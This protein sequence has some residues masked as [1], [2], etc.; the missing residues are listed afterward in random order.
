M[1]ALAASVSAILILIGISAIGFF[2]SAK[3]IIPTESLQFLSTLAV[4]VATPLYVFSNIVDKFD[5]SSSP[6][7]WILPLSWIAFAGTTFGLSLVFGLLFKPSIRSEA[8][9]SLFIYNPIFVPLAV[10]IGVFGTNS[11]YI[12]DLFLFTTFAVA[13][14]FNF[15]K[16]FFRQKG[17]MP[18][19]K[20]SL[21]WK[22][23]FNPLVRITLLALVIMLTGVNQYI[24]K[25]LIDITRYVGSM[26]FPLIMF[27]LGGY[28]YVDMKGAGRVYFL[29]II[30][31]VAVKNLAFPLIMLAILHF[32][33]LS[34]NVALILVLSAAAPPLS[35]IPILV[36]RQNGNMQITNQFLVGSFLFSIVSMPLMIMLLGVVVKP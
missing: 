35:T 7:W 17:N 22:K 25:F 21:D 18:Q 16:F 26:A 4:E 15:Y 6:E 34:Y 29:E 20:T 1:Q 12:A 33:P 32:V 19:S 27:I 13:F 24:P 10:I 8:S 2:V 36:K 9:M 28:I 5:P 11:S 23:V 3:K 30:K 31:F 14:F